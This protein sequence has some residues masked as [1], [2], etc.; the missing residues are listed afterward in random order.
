MD[1]DAK[2]GGLDSLK[3]LKSKY[4]NFDS[5]TPSVYTGG[6]GVHIFF[7]HPDRFSK[8]VKNSTSLIA[9]GVDIRGDGGY[10]VAAPSVHISGQSYEWVPTLALVEADLA[11]MPDWLIE[12]AETSQRRSTNALTEPGA[13]ILEGN[14]DSY[15]T[16]IAGSLR[17]FGSTYEAIL[18]ALRNE[19]ALRCKPPVPDEDLERITK[20]I[21]RY[22][23]ASTSVTNGNRKV[24][25]MEDIISDD[26]SKLVTLQS[27]LNEP[28]E[29]LEY[30]VD[31]LLKRGGLS[32]LVAKP[33][34]G[35]SVLAR[36]LVRAVA[37]AQPTFLGRD[38]KYG[39][40]AYL[41][42]EES[43]DEVRNHFRKMGTPE[44]VRDNILIKVGL[45][46]EDGFTW[47]RY[48]IENF[49]P[50][51]IV[52]DPI[53]S[54][55]RFKDM[56]SYSEV[57]ALLDDLMNMARTTNTHLMAVH[58]SNKGGPNGGIDSGDGILGSTAF[59]AAVDVL[60]GMNK[61]DFIRTV[62]T[63]H[64]YGTPIEKEVVYL[65]KNGLVSLRGSVE[66]FRIIKDAETIVNVM[67]I[68]SGIN[69]SEIAN[70]TGI[71]DPQLSACLIYLMEKSII[72][73]ISGAKK[74]YLYR[75]I[76]DPSTIREF[77]FEE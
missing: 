23:A 9:K 46:P 11:V 60:I 40:V 21:M 74:T 54:L 24:T 27:L 62:E 70:K 69:E 2:S 39:K 28:D 71:T 7:R 52:F 36:N 67:N 4:G 30:I 49:E 35:K 1:V 43:R 57:K 47:L 44:D 41:G 55:I 72:E 33:K 26:R 38:V 45:G 20:S 53:A 68:S 59:F 18:A 6:G 5:S 32:L 16:K 65:D 77:N 73:N 50:S 10:V 58:H 22:P 51:L 3:E 25:S 29:N 37:G 12:L 64:R 76:S 15:L 63:T 61:N 19:N 34:V 13:P 48:I 17:R 56:N 31:G 66:Q 14:R 42:L 8:V 75:L